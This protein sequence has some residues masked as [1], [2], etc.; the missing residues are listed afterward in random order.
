MYHPLKTR[1]TGLL[2][3]YIK[4]K[5]DIVGTLTQFKMLYLNVYIL[6]TDMLSK[7]VF[8]RAVSVSIYKARPML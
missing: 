4:Q 6:G 3:E 8:G 1:R 7:R 2:D 5:N